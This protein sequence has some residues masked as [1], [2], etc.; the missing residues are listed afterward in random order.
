MPTQAP[1][2]DIELRPGLTLQDHGTEFYLIT[3]G[4]GYDLTL[5]LDEAVAEQLAIFVM[6][7]L[8]LRSGKRPG[9]S[10]N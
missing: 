1:P 2:S 6:E 5:S 4:D 7:R 3:Q 10:A 9:R 8:A